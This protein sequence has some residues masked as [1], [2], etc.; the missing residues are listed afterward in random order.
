VS[1]GRGG[2]DTE[3]VDVVVVR[4]GTL[5]WKYKTDSWVKSS[6][7]IGA[8]GTVYV[9]SIDHHLYAINPDGTLKWR[10]GIGTGVPSPAIGLMVLFMWE[11]GSSFMQ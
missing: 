1:D 2:E 9:G 7:A 6:P 3:S 4:Y 11:V 10:Y 8:D 5:K